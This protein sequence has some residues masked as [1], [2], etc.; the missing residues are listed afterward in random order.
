MLTDKAR[1]LA[2]RSVVRTRA[3]ISTLLL[4]MLLVAG[5]GEAHA[6]L[7]TGAVTLAPGTSEV[8]IGRTVFLVSTDRTISLS[9]S[10][11]AEDVIEG[12]VAVRETSPAQ[13]QILWYNNGL[14]VFSGSVAQ[15]QPIRYHIPVE[16][17]AVED[18]GH[19]EK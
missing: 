10:F 15:V 8:S 14:T 19:T 12:L 1:S 13:V 17:P 4:T 7:S 11:V 5:G 18:S 2:G 3:S 16:Y 9:L 6:A